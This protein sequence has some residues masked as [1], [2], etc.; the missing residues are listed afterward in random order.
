MARYTAF[1]LSFLLGISLFSQGTDVP[2]FDNSGKII[3]I[4][5]ASDPIRLDG[6][7][8]EDSWKRAE[9]HGNFWMKYPSNDSLA[10]PATIVWVTYDEKF[11]Y[12]ATKVT[13]TPQG[14]IVQSLK[15]DIG[16]RL[17]DGLGIVLDPVNLKTNGFYFSLTPYNSQTEG[18]IGNSNDDISFTWDN[19]WYSET[20]V[21]DDY[22]TAEIAI[23]FSI[24]RYDET[25]MAWGINFIRAARSENEFH[26]WT[27]MPLQFRGTD[28]GYTGTLLWDQSPPKGGSKVSVNP[29]ASASVFADNLKNSGA[30]GGVNA[31]VDAKIAVNPAINLDLTVNPDFSNVDVDQQ[32]TNLTR[33]SIFFP[34]RRV[35][36]LENDDL[37]SGYGIPPVRPFYS[38]RLG[39]KNGVS[40]PILAGARVTGNLSKQ[41]RFGLMN[42]QTGRKG[43]N[44]ADNF[45]SFTFNQRV[46]DRS[47][48]SGYINNR[49]AFQNDQEKQDDPQGAFGRNA[50]ISLGYS[51]RSGVI[52]GWAGA[53]ASVKPG[54]SGDTYFGNAG[55]GYFGQNFTSFI[56]Y[57]HLGAHYY[58]DM[59]FVNRIENYD[60]ERD[61]VIRVGS[62]FFYNETG[63]TWYPKSG[64]LNKYSVSSN[65]FL[66]FDDAGKFNELSVVAQAV[67]DFRNASSITLAHNIN[68]VNLLFPFSFVED[69]EA[70]PLP[71]GLYDFQTTELMLVSDVRKNFV[72]GIG[73]AFGTFYNARY[74]KLTASMTARQQ[75]Y[76]S[77][78]V[79]AEY[80]NLS[81]PQPYGN[82]EFWLVAPQIEV[83]FSNS[84]FWTSFIQLNTQADNFNINSRIQWRYR[85]MSDIFLVYSDNYFTDVPL[86]N[87]DRALVLK[88]NYWLNI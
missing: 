2:I 67:F 5:K 79:T 69:E 76:F 86:F 73:G 10:D 82:Q 17:G 28:L 3:R 6:Q 77:M 45:T 40:V 32:V 62:R 74:N 24:L 38:R 27:Q 84:L 52:Q 66:A 49:Q 72:L 70:K 58:A 20:R 4:S 55:G 48:V 26:T 13:A 46:L 15:R 36:F 31:G 29:Y 75:P 22:W 43:S 78:T 44:A 35:F 34:E 61:T 1:L 9:M 41:F 53:N 83:N 63:Y 60:A 65:N 81:F 21:Y 30:K 23:P 42:I 57:T 16:L 12:I 7:H 39:S 51:S 54:I 68:R 19:T 18:L 85:P 14:N 88:I 8:D 25:K 80:N 64:P 56:D 59:G 47:V 37:F 87:K 33:F 71:A 50:G 11:L